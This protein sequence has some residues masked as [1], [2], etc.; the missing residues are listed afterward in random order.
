MS[1]KLFA[2]VGLALTLVTA[3]HAK[4]A[5]G[6]GEDPSKFLFQDEKL[7]TNFTRLR[8]SANVNENGAHAPWSE[9]YWPANKG[10]IALRYIDRDDENTD[11]FTA[12]HFNLATLKTMSVDSI[13]R[14]SASEKFD[15][16]KQHYDYPLTNRVLTQYKTDD[17]DWWGI[18]HGWT[19]AAA[20]YP[21]PLPVTV[22][23][24]DGIVIEFGASDVKALI[25]YYYAWNASQMNDR[26]E[27]NWGYRADAS[28]VQRYWQ[29]DPNMIYFIYRQLGQRCIH[30]T[31][32]CKKSNLDPAS[33]H[34]ALTNLVGNYQR[35]FVVN[36]D[37]TKQIWNQPVFGYTSEVLDSSKHH[38][39]NGAVKKV[40]VH[41]K[42]I[43]VDESHPQYKANGAMIEKDSKDLVYFLYLDKNDRIV[44]G[45]WSAGLLRRGDRKTAFIGFAW[46]ASR[47]PFLGDFAVLNTL[48]KPSQSKTTSY[49]MGRNYTPGLEDTIY[50]AA[51]F[52]QNASMMT[53]ELSSSF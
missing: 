14:L 45:K 30:G 17:P 47:V 44:G 1:Q 19:P 23:N 27:A 48:Y 16:L 28:G 21:E 33:F 50:N 22:T 51:Y 32:G 4:A 5:W 31:G 18:C 15:I 41:T 7:E 11:A 25:S 42:L 46:R 9:T 49:A 24:A 12:Q 34:L 43:Y 35:S 10:G 39:E 29:R 2:L 37:P 38:D 6:E 13:R 53:N 3:P 20:N 40:R 52:E 36:V 26:N 8:M